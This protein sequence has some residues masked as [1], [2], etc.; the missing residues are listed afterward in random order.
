MS[1]KC[2]AQLDS[3]CLLVCLLARSLVGAQISMLRWAKSKLEY[4]PF[5]WPRNG[6]LA[7]LLLLLLGRVRAG[8]DKE[9]WAAK[10]WPNKRVEEV[11]MEEWQ[12]KQQSEKRKEACFAFSSSPSARNG[13]LNP[14]QTCHQFSSAS[15]SRRPEKM[16]ESWL[17]S[18]CALHSLFFALSRSSLAHLAALYL[19]KHRPEAGR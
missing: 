12:H 15:A 5:C 6:H 11:A 3:A 7:S 18:S 19:A 1:C 8:G 9:N 13:K 14:G 16:D 4:E 10:S 2:E 17:A